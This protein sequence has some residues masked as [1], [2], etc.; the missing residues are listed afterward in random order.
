MRAG[1]RNARGIHIPSSALSL[2]KNGAV[3][4]T[5]TSITTCGSS[6][7]NRLCYAASAPTLQCAPS[8]S[9]STVQIPTSRMDH[10]LLYPRVIIVKAHSFVF[11]EYLRIEVQQTLA[12]A[13]QPLPPPTFLPC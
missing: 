2:R 11:A 1:R 8:E 3:G 10:P 13:L 6:A 7:C 12:Q 9:T 5:S 4:C